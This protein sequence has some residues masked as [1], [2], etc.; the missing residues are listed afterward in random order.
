MIGVSAR[1][2]Y[3]RLS[4][5]DQYETYSIRYGPAVIFSNEIP[6]LDA[7][8]IS[9]RWT[10]EE[11]YEVKLN[12][13]NYVNIRTLSSELYEKRKDDSVNTN[14]LSVFQ[15]ANNATGTITVRFIADTNVNDEYQLIFQNTSNNTDYLYIEGTNNNV[16]Q[17]IHDYAGV[18]YDNGYSSVDKT[19]VW[20]STQNGEQCN[21]IKEALEKSKDVIYY[22]SGNMIEIGEVDGEAT[23]W[24]ALKKYL[25]LSQDI[26]TSYYYDKSNNKYYEAEYKGNESGKGFASN[27]YTI[28]E[29]QSEIKTRGK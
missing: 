3:G 25:N 6:G 7:N 8:F 13:S 29:L 20:N 16:I 21:L 23:G 17:G 5:D 9:P 22:K 4:N 14:I 28:K 26:S 1:K 27:I 2:I 11:P 19:E 10:D 15:E 24:N 18:D 12:F